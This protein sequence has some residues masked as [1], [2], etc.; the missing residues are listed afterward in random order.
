MFLARSFPW[1]ISCAF[2]PYVLEF[3]LSIG[4]YGFVLRQAGVATANVANALDL[5]SIPDKKAP[6]AF[7]LHGAAMPAAIQVS[8]A[9]LCCDGMPA[10]SGVTGD[11]PGGAFASVVWSNGPGK[12]TLA[13]TIADV[14]TPD[15]GSVTFAL[16]GDPTMPGDTARDT[17]SEAIYVPQRISLFSRSPRDNGLYPPII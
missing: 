11:I 5:C 1:E 17:S 2:R 7:E 12:S 6:W 13:R 16:S 10:L 14:L 9:S 4:G 15:S 3:A 8:G